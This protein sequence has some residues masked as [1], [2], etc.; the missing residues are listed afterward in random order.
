MIPFMKKYFNRPIGA[1]LIILLIGAAGTLSISAQTDPSAQ[2]KKVAEKSD[3]P[4]SSGADSGSYLAEA[5]KFKIGTDPTFWIL[6]LLF[7]FALAV[8]IERIWIFRKNRGK[9]AELVQLLT[10]KIPNG[11]SDIDGLSGMISRGYGMEGRVASVTLKGW[12]YGI[13]AM[14]EYAGS[15]MLAEKRNLERRL[16]V[17][18]TLGN[19]TPFIG[20]LGTVLGIMKAFR[21]LAYMGDAGPA[22]VMKGISEALVATALG[23]GVAIPCVIAFNVLSRIVKDKLSSAEEIS[24]LLRALRLTTEKS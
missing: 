19:N 22:V 20:L 7:N 1:A 14:K 23:L 8:T 4:D 15:S 12:K 11:G 3:A 6:L 18:S 9:N 16:V 10:E 13:D 21:D 5:G 17:L 24:T 2:V